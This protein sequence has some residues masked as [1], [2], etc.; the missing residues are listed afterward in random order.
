MK[1]G[2][3][4]S[5]IFHD[6]RVSRTNDGLQVEVLDYH[7]GLLTLTPAQLA[8]FGFVPATPKDHGAHEAQLT[9]DDIGALANRAIDLLE[10]RLDYDAS[11]LAEIEEL[12]Q[13]LRRVRPA[14]GRERTDLPP[15]ASS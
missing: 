5:S 3:A 9:G 13:R 1:F 12:R 8:E 4:V 11:A 6:F 15:R 2:E 10:R 14:R 7:A